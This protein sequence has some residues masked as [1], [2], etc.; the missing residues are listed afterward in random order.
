MTTRDPATDPQ[1]LLPLHPFELRILL[2]LLDGPLHGYRIV[3][4]I[5]ERDSGW[6][7]IFP[8]NLYRRL[9]DLTAKGLIEETDAPADGEADPR[10]RYFRITTLG[11]EVARAEARRLDELLREAREKRLLAPSEGVP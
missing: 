2:A 4:A 6:K 8:A 3:K 9:R 1:D 11:R 5:E 7:R 10:R